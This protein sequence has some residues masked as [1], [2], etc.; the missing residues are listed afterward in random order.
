MREK[1]VREW[2][3]KGGRKNDGKRRGYVHRLDKV[4]TSFF[5]TNFPEE[6]KAVDLWPKFARFGRV[7]E[8]YIPDKRDKQGRRFGK[9]PEMVADAVAGSSEVVCE[10]EVEPDALAKLKG[11]FVGFLSEDRDC[12]S[13]QHNFLMDGY[14][15]IKITPL[16][17]MK[18][19]ISSSV[20]GEVKELVGTVGWWCTW[21]E[22]F[23]EWSPS[24][25]SN[26]RVTWLNCYGIPLHIWGDCYFSVHRL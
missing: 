5:F 24:W 7:G 15:H 26:Q 16:G 3:E 8:V 6:V 20:D 2:V 17:F 4:A 21:F 14:H 23:E 10:V 13:I 11:A 12:R 25:V 1:V 19:L 18:V 22:R 9:E